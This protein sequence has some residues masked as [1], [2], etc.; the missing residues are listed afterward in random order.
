MVTCLLLHHHDNEAGFARARDHSLPRFKGKR[1]KISLGASEIGPLLQTLLKKMVD[2]DRAI[3]Y[4]LE[5]LRKTEE[6]WYRLEREL[7][8]ERA[9]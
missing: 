7:N 2:K 9:E 3:L 8:R 1:E 4:L 5:R 6:K